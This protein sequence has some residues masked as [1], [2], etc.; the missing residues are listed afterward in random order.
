MR[1]ALLSG[2]FGEPLEVVAVTGQNFP[3]YRPAYRN[4]YY[5]DRKTGGG[6]VQDALTH[7]MNAAEWLVGPIDRVV[8]DL[9]HQVLEGVDVEDTVHVLTRHGSV[10]GS[11]T[12]NQHQAPN[13]FTLTIICRGGT[14]RF[15]GH[16]N[17]WRWM[18]KPGDEWTDENFPPM[19]RD[20]MF[21][22]QANAFLDAVEQQAAPACDIGAGW[23]TLRVNLAILSSAEHHR[24]EQVNSGDR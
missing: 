4:T 3:F 15:E 22:L 7:L 21:I 17:R 16:Q 12:L 11:Y 6:A 8:A 23:Q 20:T 19:E 1:E 9:D 5:R 2:R 24:W 10:M 14:I 13:E 18:L